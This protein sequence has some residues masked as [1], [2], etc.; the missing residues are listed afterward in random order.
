MTE[1]QTTRSARQRDVPV[2][3]ASASRRLGG[4]KRTINGTPL[5]EIFTRVGVIPLELTRDEVVR[6]K[7]TPR[8]SWRTFSTIFGGRPRSEWPQCD[9]IP[10]YKK[11]LSAHIRAQPYVPTAP[12]K[13]G[14]VICL[15]TTVW[16]PLDNGHTFHVFSSHDSLLQYQGEYAMPRPRQVELDWNDLSAN[17]SMLK[18]CHTRLYVSDLGCSARTCG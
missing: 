11:I 14:L 6:A 3:S 2:P 12:G 18:S 17:V 5:A 1:S 9:R 4:A 15:P 16:T 8:I 13:P 10:A 7:E